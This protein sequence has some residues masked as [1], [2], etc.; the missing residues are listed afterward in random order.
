[1]AQKNNRLVDLVLGWTVDDKWVPIYWQSPVARSG[2]QKDSDLILSKT[3]AIDHHALVVAQSGSG[4]SF[5]LGRL[6]EEILLRTKCR[7]VVFDPNSDFRRFSEEVEPSKWKTAKFD[8]E[9]KEKKAGYLP[10]ETTRAPFTRRWRGLVLPVRVYTTERG[11][12]S[13]TTPIQINWLDFPID[14]FSDDTDPAF[15]SEMRHCHAFMQAFAHLTVVAK[16]WQWRD[17][18]GRTVMEEA[19]RFC[20]K[21]VDQERLEVIGALREKFG[22]R[23][24]GCCHGT[25]QCDDSIRSAED[26][27]RWLD[28]TLDSAARRR[29]NV[30][31]PVFRAYFSLAEEAKH[32]G[33]FSEIGPLPPTSPVRVHVIDL[34]SINDRAYRLM[35]VSKFLNDEWTLARRK[36]Q[37]AINLPPNVSDERVPTFIVVD[38][39]HHLVPSDPDGRASKRLRDQFRMV[40]AEGRKFGLFLIVASQ[41]PDKLDPMVV[42]ECENRAIMRLNSETVIEETAKLLGIS[43]AI[44]SQLLRACL[45]LKRGR[46]LLCGPWANTDKDEAVRL[47]SAMRRTKE[48]GRNLSE[49]YWAQPYKMPK[50]RKP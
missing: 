4:K 21:T 34:P 11:G 24:E 23:S 42:S 32:S 6:L 47:Y 8:P 36:W 45:S 28:P 18:Q 26:F 2:A 7:V 10:H 25:D 12:G 20:E 41:R 37:E 14:W 19:R 5:F 29:V 48:G 50:T 27:D 13:G 22:S 40:A 44:K 9:E 33:I 46:A 43:N 31:L 1:M 39:A 3:E 15:Q 17:E 30:S 16:T 38:E 49:E 35:A